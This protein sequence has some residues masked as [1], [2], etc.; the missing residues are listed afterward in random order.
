MLKLILLLIIILFSLPLIE[1]FT[2]DE[3]ED[4]E[5]C[6]YIEN[7]NLTNEEKEILIAEESLMNEKLD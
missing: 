6:L 5:T 4:Y 7:S 3:I 2:C 1:A